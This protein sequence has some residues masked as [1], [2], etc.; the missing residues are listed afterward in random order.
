MMNNFILIGELSSYKPIAD[1]LFVF[2]LK[3]KYQFFTSGLIFSI[4]L[5]KIQGVFL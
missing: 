2:L 1:T 5:E 3:H 4:A